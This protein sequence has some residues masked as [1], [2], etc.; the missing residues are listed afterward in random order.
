LLLR[1]VGTGLQT[2]VK[3]AIGGKANLYQKIIKKE[4]I[5]Q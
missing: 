1:Q 5:A 4:L 3:A 2:V